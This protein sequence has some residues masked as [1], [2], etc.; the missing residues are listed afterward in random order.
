M[1]GIPGFAEAVLVEITAS[2]VGIP[3]DKARIGRNV[4]FGLV[5]LIFRIDPSPERKSPANRLWGSG[6]ALRG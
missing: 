1:R 6:S 2:Q 5:R 4:F 3:E